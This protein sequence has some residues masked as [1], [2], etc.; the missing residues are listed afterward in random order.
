MTRFWLLSGIALLPVIA[1]KDL[2]AQAPR[3]TAYTVTQIGAMMPPGA[4]STVYRD[5]N[6]ALVETQTPK[7]GGG[8]GSRVRTLYDLAAHKDVSW[9]A[10]TTPTGCG[11]GTFS[12]SWGDPWDAS[13]EMMSQVNSKH[14]KES[15]TETVNGMAAKVYDVTDPAMK[16]RI[17]YDPKSN[18]AIKAVLTTPDGKQQTLLEVTQV[19]L[20]PP[21]ASIFAVPPACKAAADAPPP[22]TEAETIA[23]ETGGSAADYSKA[24]MPPPSKAS[25][26][27]LV[28]VVKA[29][30]MEPINSGFQF[31]IDFTYDIDHPPHYTVGLSDS[32]HSTFSGG[33]LHEVT[34]SFRNGTLRLDN[35]PPHFYAEATFPGGND[36]S[37]LLYR[38][39]VKPQTVLLLVV[40]NPAKLSEGVDW[41]WAKSGKYAQ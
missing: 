22:P 32:N 16:A 29:A 34:S 26:S 23:T 4:V 37:G 9:D 13:L 11:T 39:C 30:T 10:S 36:T 1:P 27:V 5:G 15:G 14:V 19:S 28:R 8:P 6:K 33:G 24:S 38:Q 25:C 12:G 41:L 40:K 17:W 21:P 2:R 3:P 31:A 20:A 7:P 18:L 35:V